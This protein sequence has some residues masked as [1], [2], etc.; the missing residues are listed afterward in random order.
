MI[1]R[2]LILFCIVCGV[3][4]GCASQ[5]QSKAEP[6]ELV[7]A[8]QSQTE[9]QSTEPTVQQ[10]S[11]QSEKTPRQKVEEM[12]GLTPIERILETDFREK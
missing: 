8:E 12:F 10:T 5:Q 2:V 3:L 6:E 4:S 1:K 9:D 7:S 11:A